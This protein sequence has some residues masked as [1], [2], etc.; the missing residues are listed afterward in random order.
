M[1]L[2]LNHILD[3]TNLFFVITSQSTVIG[4]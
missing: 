2:T 3:F 4:H 1:V